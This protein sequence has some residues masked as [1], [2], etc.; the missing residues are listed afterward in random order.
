M[1]PVFPVPT[2][3]ASETSIEAPDLEPLGRG[4][5]LMSPEGVLAM[6]LAALGLLA[7]GSMV[8]VP[9]RHSR[10][11]SKQSKLESRIYEAVQEIKDKTKLAGRPGGWGSGSSA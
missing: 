5:S 8:Y 11:R 9:V 1:D 2:P 6:S 3:G 7:L 10:I 4:F